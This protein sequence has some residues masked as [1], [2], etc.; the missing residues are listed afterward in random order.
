LIIVD[1][2][3]VIFV[4]GKAHGGG[5]FA[6]RLIG[7]LFS[8]KVDFGII[9]NDSD[10]YE[11]FN[12]E[13]NRLSANEDLIYF[14][15]LYRGE[16][17][18]QPNLYREKIF[19]IHGLRMLE[20]PYDKYAYKYV[21]GGLARIL[22]FCKYYFF[23]SH[24]YRKE[25]NFI[26]RLI[27][28]YEDVKLITPSLHS[29]YMLKALF[30]L[31]INPVCIPPFLSHAKSLTNHSSCSDRYILALGGDRWVK[32][33]YRF[34]QAFRSLKRAGALSGVKLMVVG[35]PPF[36]NVKSDLL[37]DVVWRDYV[38]E[39]ELH[40]LFL[41]C[42]FLAYPSLNEGFGYPVADALGYGKPVL[43]GS[44]SALNEVYNGEVIFADPMSILE[45][46]SRILYI[47]DRCIDNKELASRRIAFNHHIRQEI[48]RGWDKYF[49]D[50]CSKVNR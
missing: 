23:K 27:H 24:Y 29:S 42:I 15:P 20:M 35:I 50:L 44:R 21:R 2:S 49:E 8:R 7:Y 25:K 40:G 4:G 6:L 36:A 45:I 13:S 38:D 33:T 19:Y 22:A 32:N 31:K 46:Q 1:F 3:S 48:E 18:E 9:N 11:E 10:F 30:P 37:D 28:R 5:D 41:N 47:M 26:Y 12:I 34:L 43:C 17:V 39:G 16:E 14:N